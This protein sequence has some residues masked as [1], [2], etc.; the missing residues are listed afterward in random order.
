M[1]VLRDG[2]WEE[3]VESEF[4]KLKSTADILAFVGVWDTGWS[5]A[6][7]RKHAERFADN[8]LKERLKNGSI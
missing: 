5:L 8:E 7:L 1:V 6:N 2:R 3:V 4:Q